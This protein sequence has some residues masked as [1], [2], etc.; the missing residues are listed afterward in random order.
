MELR[1]L[2]KALREQK[3]GK[4][5]RAEGKSTKLTAQKTDSM[6]ATINEIFQFAASHGYY[7]K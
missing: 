6:T 4:C 1:K 5:D 7:F 3:K 2:R